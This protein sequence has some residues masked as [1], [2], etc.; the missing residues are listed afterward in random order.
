MDQIHARAADIEQEELR[1][2]QAADH[3]LQRAS[4]QRNAVFLIVAFVNLFFIGWAYG[5]SGMRRSFV[6]N[7]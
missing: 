2:V 7:P 4:T 6:A 3:A 5:G 1:S